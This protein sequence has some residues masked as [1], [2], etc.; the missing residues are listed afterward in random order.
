MIDFLKKY[1]WLWAALLPLC[2]ALGLLSPY[3]GLVA[4][5]LSAVGLMLLGA[6]GGICLFYISMLILGDSRNPLLEFFKDGRTVVLLILAAWTLYDLMTRK[7]R[8]NPGF[9]WI[10]PFI[11]LAFISLFLSSPVPFLGFQRTVSY[12][13]VAFVAFH[14]YP[15]W[16]EQNNRKGY[17]EMLHFVGVVMGIGILFW[18]LRLEFVMLGVRFQG[19]YGNPNG[20]GLT[21]LNVLPVF[22]FYKLS[23]DKIYA[24]TWWGYLVVLMMSLLLSNSRNGLAGCLMFFFFLWW[25]KVPWRMFVFFFVVIPFL[26]W[27]F[28]TV[29]IVR[30]LYDMG[31]GEA[32]RADSILE[33]SGRTLSW[34]FAIDM[35][36]EHF[37]FGAGFSYQEYV[38][39]NLVPPHLAIFREMSSTWNSYLTLMMNNGLLG[40]ISFFVFVFAQLRYSKRKAIMGAYLLAMMLAAI[41]E[42]WLTAS[43][44]AYLIYFFIMMAYLPKIEKDFS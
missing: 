14:F 37:W 12:F 42:T 13:L 39:D 31:L 21:C 29:D 6:R 19:L 8:W 23:T 33:A 25:F 34:A 41:Y 24:K 38:Y 32:L 22:V 35:I 1:A 10:L 43:L 27:F 36:P 5:F 26:V 17:A 9:K 2:A 18:I 7:Y 3:V 44:N 16:M 28:T 20:I 11:V 30:L 15:Y 40:T 4:I